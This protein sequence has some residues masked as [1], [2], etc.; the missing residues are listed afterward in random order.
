MG[1]ASWRPEMGEQSPG[2]SQ[3]EGDPQRRPLP[4]R[5][6]YGAVRSEG[7]VQLAAA[8]V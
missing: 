8:A 6:I 2:F 4:Q 3:G 7:Q 5:Q 1:G